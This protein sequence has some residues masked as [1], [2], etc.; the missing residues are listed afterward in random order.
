MPRTDISPDDWRSM[1][2]AFDAAREMLAE[3]AASQA[4]VYQRRIEIWELALDLG[5]RAVKR[6]T[7]ATYITR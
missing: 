5:E 6:Y 1:A 7:G 3:L 2:R 4:P